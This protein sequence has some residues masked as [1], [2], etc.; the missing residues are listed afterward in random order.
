MENE[1][2]KQDIWEKEHEIQQNLTRIKQMDSNLRMDNLVNKSLP[3]AYATAAANNS[4]NS[5]ATL[6]TNPS[7]SRDTTLAAV[8]NLCRNYLKVYVTA[9]DI[10]M[11]HRLLKSRQNT[12]QPVF[13]RFTS[14]QKSKT[15]S[16]VL[17]K[18]RNLCPLTTLVYINEYLTK[19]LTNCLRHVDEARKPKKL[20]ALGHKITTYLS[21]ICLVMVEIL[22]K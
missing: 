10:S 2:L 16:T 22:S 4:N 8:I 5:S 6:P 18:L 11:A 7:E 15:W 14:R 17:K 21:N 20:Q 9:N 13:V 19:K 1:Q 3:E 12:T